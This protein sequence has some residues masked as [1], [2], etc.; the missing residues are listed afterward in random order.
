MVVSRLF[1]SVSRNV[2]RRALLLSASQKHQ[3]PLISHHLHSLA[4]ESRNK[5]VTSQIPLLNHSAFNSFNFQQ[6]RMSS[7]A[8]PEPTEKEDGSSTVV[9]PTN[10]KVSDQTKASDSEETEATDQ[11]NESDSDSEDQ[12]D[13]SVDD[14]VKVVTEKE[15]LL[16]LKHEEIKAMQDKVLRSYAEMENVMERTRRDAENSKKFA[17][18]N[19]AKS[20]LDVADNL[21]RASSVVK[22]S[23]SKIDTSKDAAGAV[24]LL[25]TLLEGVNM[26]EKQLLEIFKK[27]GLEKYDPTNEPFDPHRHNAVFQVPDN[28]KPPGTV[29]HVLKAGYMLHD[30]VIRPAEVGVTQAMENGTADNAAGKDSEA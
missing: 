28:A 21:E 11:N 25:K 29:A 2:G 22:V 13:L 27:Y 3:V 12:S 16:K 6:F 7:S 1:S 9:D 19:F 8:K 23:F 5:I 26:T 17:I 15:E 14:L 4:Y 24:P 18:Q 20:L 30:R 10:A